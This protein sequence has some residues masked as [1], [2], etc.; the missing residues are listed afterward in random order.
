MCGVHERPA[1]NG[2]ERNV[3]RGVRIRTV[4]Y[5]VPRCNARRNAD[6]RWRRGS[7]RPGDDHEVACHFSAEVDT[8]PAA[9]IF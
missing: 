3:A 7:I 1:R 6:L 8:A 4:G 9:T 2:R 5:L